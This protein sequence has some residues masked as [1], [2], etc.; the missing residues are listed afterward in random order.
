ME[1]VLLGIVF[2]VAGI[3]AAVGGRFIYVKA[4]ATP[5]HADPKGVKSVID[6][7][8]KPAWAAAAERGREIVR[9]AAADQNLPGVSVAVG[10]GGEILW[11]EGFGWGDIESHSPITPQ[12]RF[13]IGDVS[14]A[15]TS[16]GVGLLLERH[17]LDLDAEI[18]S[19]VPE[20]PKK[21]WPMTLRQ[22]MAQTAGLPQDEGDEASLAPCEQTKDGLKLFDDVRLQFEPGT[23]YHTSSYGWILVSNAIEGAAHERFFRFMR[24]QVFE[25][26]GMTATRQYSANEQ[27]ADLPTFYFPR[28]GGDTRYGPELARDGDHTCYAGAYAFLST[29]SDLVRYGMAVNSGRFLQPA[30]VATLHTPQRLT[31]GEPNS[32]GLGWIV[33]SVPLAGQPAKMVGHGTKVD[34]IGGSTYLMTFPERDLVVAVASNESFADMKSVALA[35]AQAF[36]AAPAH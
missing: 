25:P 11:A 4:T 27:V 23:K 22:L 8:A 10:R 29:P 3:A 17:Q 21:Q 18:H 6:E 5:L 35:V 16:G 32:Y 7:A 36:A 31:T 34:F 20:Y 33:E 30:T 1:T 13:R 19:Y 28:F 9:V 14:K 2:V 15:L 12:T 24:A 26:L